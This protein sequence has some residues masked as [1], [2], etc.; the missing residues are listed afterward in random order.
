MEDVGLTVETL[1]LFPCAVMVERG[2]NG[3]WRGISRR[4]G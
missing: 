4:G 1:E 2:R 3:L